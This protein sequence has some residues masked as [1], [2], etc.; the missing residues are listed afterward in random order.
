MNTKDP[1]LVALEFNECISHQD[2]DGLSRL[3]T[4]DHTFIDRDGKVVQP[5]EAM[6]KS[7]KQF[8]EVFP[9]YKNTFTRV[10]SRE[11][12]VVILGHAFWSQEQPY[13]PAI[14]TASIRDDLVSEWRIYA[15]TE[16]NRKAFNLV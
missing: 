13:D 16:A 7:W 6:I 2:L 12:L 3:M 8:F 9:G 1:K 4:D 11:N 15:D 14:W 10:E 5:K